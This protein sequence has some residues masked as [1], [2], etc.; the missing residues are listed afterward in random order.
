QIKLYPD[1]RI[2][3]AYAGA[4]PANAV[5]GIA[6]GGAKGSSSLVSFRNDP[7]ADYAAAVVE[8]F[9]NSLEIDIVLVAQRFSQT[10]DDAYDYL[11]IYNNEGIGA[12]P[13]AVAYES[14]VRSSGSGWG[15]PE[16]DNGQQYGSSGRLRSVL[17]LGH[18][19]QYP[20]DPN[21]TVTLRGAANDTPLTVIG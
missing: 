3:F 9:G 19:T 12:M 20:K 13:G 2:V 5:V 14:T 1:G 10:H 8:R 15:V 7:P 4:K 16:T 6:P 21:G 18:L 11:V 17:N